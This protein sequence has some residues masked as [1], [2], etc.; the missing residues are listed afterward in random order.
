MYN[1]K[2]K[3]ENNMEE[4]KIQSIIESILFASGAEV[5]LQELMLILEIPREKIEN[6][7]MKIMNIYIQ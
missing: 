3:S 4:K 2:R 6:I 1:K 5:K 7:I